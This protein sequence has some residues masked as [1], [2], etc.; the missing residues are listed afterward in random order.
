MKQSHG[1]TR[2]WPSLVTAGAM[3]L[4]VGL[5]AWAMRSLPLGTAYTV[6][7][8]V[9]AVVG[10]GLGRSGTLDLVGGRGVVP[11]HHC[12]YVRNL[13]GVRVE[14]LARLHAAWPVAGEGGC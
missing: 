11:P 2:L 14:A 8:G 1:F 9:G 10:V 7:P 12:R 4:S 13:L 5:L 3:A 6:W